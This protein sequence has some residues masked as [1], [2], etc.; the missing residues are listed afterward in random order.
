MEVLFKGPLNGLTEA[1]KCNYIIYW[2]GDHGM[3][4]VDKWTT[5]NKINDGN[6]ETLKTYWDRFDEYVHP[7]TNK[8]IAVVELKQ[9]FQGTMSLED[10]HTKAIRLVTQ[11][12]YEGDAKDQVLRDTI[13]SGIASEK[14]RSKIVK[15]GHAVSLNRVMEIARL[16]VSTQHH[17]DRIQETVK[18]NYVQY[19]KSTKN[20]KGKKSTQSGT[21]GGSYRGDRGH[22]T[23][24]KPHGKGKKLPFPQDTC[25]RCGKGK[26]QKTQD[27]KTLDAVCRG[28][29]KKGHFEKVCLKAKHSTHSLEVPQASTSSAGAGTSEPLYFDDDR[30]PVFAHMVSV[31]HANKHL[32]KF[33][34]ALD[35]TTLRDRNKMENSRFYWLH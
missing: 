20:K 11:V 23:S 30:Q 32:I 31:L 28:C 34:I 8:L 9:L 5:E 22:R 25:Y 1:V 10:F 19:G 24:S 26:H 12:G 7:Q 35:Y 15:E 29:G 27:C 13:I 16:E 17:L 33:P 3:D 2:S 21:S 14:V 4:L 18:V 6:K